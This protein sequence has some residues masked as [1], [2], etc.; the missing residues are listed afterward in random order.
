[1]KKERAISAEKPREGERARKRALTPQAGGGL[2]WQSALKKAA[3]LAVGPGRAAVPRGH[4]RSAL[5]DLNSKI[6]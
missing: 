4:Q 3:A 5:C 6:G 1:M 2:N